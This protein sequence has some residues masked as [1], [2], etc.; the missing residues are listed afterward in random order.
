[1][2]IQAPHAQWS[3]PPAGARRQP[4]SYIRAGAPAARGIALTRFLIDINVLIALLSILH[5]SSMTE[6]TRGLGTK[7]G[8]LGPM[9]YRG[10][11][12]LANCRARAI[13]E[14]S[15]RARRGSSVTD[16]VVCRFPATISGRT[17]LPS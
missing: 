16:R 5:T 15:W 2:R 13:S 6:R 17:T 9:P 11:R 4:K 14:L 7:G 10:K 8:M 1:M 12:R 3:S